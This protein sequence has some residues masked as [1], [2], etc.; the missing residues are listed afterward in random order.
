MKPVFVNDE[1]KCIILEANRDI[2]RVFALYV[3]FVEH[4]FVC[5]IIPGCCCLTFVFMLAVCYT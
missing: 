4:D 2:V 1:K 5:V 3:N